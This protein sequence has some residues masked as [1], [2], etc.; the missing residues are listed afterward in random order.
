MS[1]WVLDGK[2]IKFNALPGGMWFR[3]VNGNKNDIEKDYFCRYWSN[4]GG[5]A[6]SAIS[7][8]SFVIL[9]RLKRHS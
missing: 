3:H 1:K 8:D 2:Q 5:N 7:P 9:A 4:I 6:K